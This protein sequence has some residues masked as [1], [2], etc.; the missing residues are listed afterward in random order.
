MFTEMLCFTD[1][2]E[3]R[4]SRAAKF[5][6]TLDDVTASEAGVLELCCK[7][8]GDPHPEVEWFFEGSIVRN[9]GNFILMTSSDS[10]TLKVL[11]VTMSNAGKYVCKIKVRFL[12]HIP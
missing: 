2:E 6:K 11:N 8:Q 7:V 1:L 3:R 5:T 4:K 9:E 12:K 10:V